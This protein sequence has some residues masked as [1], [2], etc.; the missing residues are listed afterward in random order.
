MRRN[1]NKSRNGRRVLDKPNTGDFG[2]EIPTGSSNPNQSFL[3]STQINPSLQTSELKAKVVTTNL[4]ANTWKTERA[5]VFEIIGSVP[6]GRYYVNYDFSVFGRNQPGIRTFSLYFGSIAPLITSITYPAVNAGQTATFSVTATGTAA[7]TYQ[8]QRQPASGGGFS[9][10][11]GAN[12]ASYTTPATSVTGGTVNHNDEYRCVVTNAVSSTTSSVC[13]LKVLALSTSAPIAVTTDSGAGL[14]LGFGSVGTRLLTFTAADTGTVGSPVSISIANTGTLPCDWSI[15][16]PLYFSLSV[17]SGTL[18]A[19][20][21]VNITGN[22]STAGTYALTLISASA[23]I[24]GAV[25]SVVMEAAYVPPAVPTNFVPRNAQTMLF[26]PLDTQFKTVTTVSP[27]PFPG[28]YNFSLEGDT[29]RTSTGPTA[30]YID[31]QAGWEWTNLGG[32]WLGGDL[33]PQGSTPWSSSITTAPNNTEYSMDV[34]TMYRYIN[35]NDHWAAFFLHYTVGIR[36]LASRRHVNLAY[37]PRV[38]VTYTDAST[39]T[40]AIT[41][42]AAISNGSSTPATWA[43]TFNL[44]IAME[45]EKPNPAKTIASALLKFTVTGHFGSAGAIIA[46]L[47]NPPTTVLDGP[48]GLSASTGLLDLNIGSQTGVILAQR[49]IDGSVRSDFI[50]AEASSILDTD[51]DPILYGIAGAPNPAKFP[52]RGALKWMNAGDLTYVDSSY[53]ADGFEPLAPGLGAIKVTIPKTTPMADGYVGTQGGALGTTAKLF[54]PLEYMSTLQHGRMRYYVRFAFERPPTLAEKY[55]FFGSGSTD[56]VDYSGKFGPSF[57]HNCTKG[58]VS[59]SAG[60]G[61][62]WQGRMQWVYMLQDT[63]GPNAGGINLSAHIKSDFYYNQPDGYNY[64]TMSVAFNERFGQQGG[65]GSMIQEQ[66]WHCLEIDFKLNTVTNSGLGFIPDGHWIVYMDN[67]KVLEKTGL[68]MRTLPIQ[69]RIIAPVVTPGVSNVGNGVFVDNAGYNNSTNP[70]LKYADDA[71][72]IPETINI[73]FNSATTYTPVG[74]FYG[75]YPQGTVGVNYTSL[76]YHKWRIDAGVTPWQAGDTINLVFPSFD[77]EGPVPN[78]LTPQRDL[79]IRDLWFNWFHGG[80][81]EPPMNIHGYITGLVVADGSVVPHIGPMKLPVSYPAWRPSAGG[82]LPVSTS[83]VLNDIRPQIQPWNPTPGSTGT[84][85]NGVYQFSSIT[86]YCGGVWVQS[87]RKFVAMGGGHATIC[88]PALYNWDAPSSTWGWLEAPLATDGMASAPGASSNNLVDARAAASAAYP[89]TKFDPVEW[90]WLGDWSG[91]PAGFEQPGKIFPEVSHSYF[92]YVWVPGTSVGNTNGYILKL[93]PGSGRLPGCTVPTRHYFDLDTNLWGHTPNYRSNPS[94]NAGG[95][96]YFGGSIDRVF[97]MTNT[98]GGAYR[99]QLDVWNPATKLWS[100]SSTTNDT[101]LQMSSGGL[102]AHIPSN[103][104]I[105]VCPSTSQSG[106]ITYVGATQHQF[107]AVN[108][109]ALKAGTSATWIKLT[110]SNPGGTWPLKI[111]GGGQCGSVTWTYCPDNGKFY[112][113]NGI[114]N[115]TQLWCLSPPAGAVTQG[116]YLSGTWTVSAE[117]LTNPIPSGDSG[118]GTNGTQEPYN[119]LIWDDTAKCL[120]W[121]DVSIVNKP[122]AIRPAA[123]TA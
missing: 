87:L 111:L 45:S 43:Q 95:S 99:N 116:D 32:D 65:W 1:L 17:S 6:D 101:T 91:W 2:Y 92:G 4:P 78:M 46:R 63:P 41:C 5:G 12:S 102:I 121:F 113:I 15:T 120:L 108:A 70:A 34:T 51:F 47:A 42:M 75:T 104:L 60:S 31:L 26:Q 16:P 7:L 59:G 23:T 89:A 35:N 72:A 55:L 52:Q 20:A 76:R 110:I 25:Q 28:T 96:I 61:L 9:D 53:N 97:S 62:G 118:G 81:T 122:V 49:Y 114:H 77:G 74:S 88:I 106:P 13:R 115:S 107:W 103:L 27:H 50:S 48:A 30:Q 19:G 117:T 71:R 39:Q 69:H 38:E 66:Q 18:A 3:I 73:T 109:S 93:C 67:K 24:T 22:A 105:H 100:I 86:A 112:A 80:K 82:A 79:G 94:A 10:V 21:T 54:L 85:A 64:A 37:R 56:W 68:V 29:S 119:R 8:W 58:G 40:L 11:P 98:S 44:P 14:R 33:T 83:T 84:W 36:T 123:I 90:E 57:N